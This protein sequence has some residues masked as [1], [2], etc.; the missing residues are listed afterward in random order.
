MEIGTIVQEQTEK[1]E[2]V[3]PQRQWALTRILRAKNQMDMNN[4]R[5]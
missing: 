3:K 5:G 4:K 2:M 1:N